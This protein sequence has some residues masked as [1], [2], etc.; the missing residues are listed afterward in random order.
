MLGF[1]SFGFILPAQVPGLLERGRETVPPGE[2]GEREE[3]GPWGDGPWV[4]GR[5]GWVR[6]RRW[7]W[8]QGEDEGEEG[9]GGLT[10]SDLYSHP[11][12]SFFLP[13]LYPQSSQWVGHL[14]PSES[15]RIPLAPPVQQ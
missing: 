14:L 7:A 3:D 10:C 5:E 6:G 4:Q 1:A 15:R 11:I 8:Q 2:P 12:S 13:P 9:H